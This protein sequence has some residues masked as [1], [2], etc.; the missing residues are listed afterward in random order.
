MVDVI[1]RSNLFILKFLRRSVRF[2]MNRFCFVSICKFFNNLFQFGNVF[3]SRFSWLAILII[4]Q[5]DFQ[6]F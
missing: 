6:S 2:C 4:K 3:C 1:F 5:R